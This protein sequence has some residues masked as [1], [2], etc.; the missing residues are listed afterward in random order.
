MMM[1][2][3]C[4]RPALIV[5]LQTLHRTMSRDYKILFRKFHRPRN[6]FEPAVD[7]MAEVETTRGDDR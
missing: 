3:G 7:S 1:I 4:P 5:V 2:R 6:D